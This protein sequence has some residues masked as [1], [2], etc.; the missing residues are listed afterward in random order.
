M[1]RRVAFTTLSPEAAAEMGRPLETAA[2]TMPALTGGQHLNNMISNWDH[3]AAG[4]SADTVPK[5]K[6]QKRKR[7]PAKK[8]K[9]VQRKKKTKNAYQKALLQAAL[10]PPPRSRSR[11]RVSLGIPLTNRTTLR[12]LLWKLPWTKRPLSDLLNMEGWLSRRA[13]LQS[14]IHKIPQAKKTL[15]A[16]ASSIK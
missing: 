2:D 15:L 12:S 11:S 14:I 9:T 8:K 13:T 6:A 16:S 7:T 3:L 5:P 10:T 4:G 1:S